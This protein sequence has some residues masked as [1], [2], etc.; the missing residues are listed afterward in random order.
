M[1]DFHDPAELRKKVRS[2]FGQF[3]N[4]ISKILPGKK[5]SFSDTL[6]LYKDWMEMGCQK[7]T[8]EMLDDIR[9]EQA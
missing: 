9:R 5:V 4:I 1:S 3:T 6:Q 7:I 8:P 2:T